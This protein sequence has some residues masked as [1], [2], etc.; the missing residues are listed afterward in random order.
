MAD[1]FIR[2]NFVYDRPGAVLAAFRAFVMERRSVP[3]PALT[4]IFVGSSS[5]FGRRVL[6]YQ[7]QLVTGLDSLYTSWDYIW[8]SLGDSLTCPLSLIDQDAGAHSPSKGFYK[9]D[10]TFP[11]KTELEDVWSTYVLAGI[12]AFVQ[13]CTGISATLGDP[14]VTA[15]VTDLIYHDGAIDTY[16]ASDRPVIWVEELI[17]TSDQDGGEGTVEGIE[18]AGQTKAQGAATISGSTEPIALALRDLLLVDT[19]LTMQTNG[20]IFS[21][22]SRDVTS[23]TP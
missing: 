5:Q 2:H 17:E 13:D 21:V 15:I 20:A 10:A 9:T 18:Y 16:P 6:Y 1:S 14:A 23:E 19:D 22:R 12:R 4:T 7:E 11:S 8:M 3:I